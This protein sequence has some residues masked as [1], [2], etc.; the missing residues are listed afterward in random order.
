MDVHI[1]D[2]GDISVGL[3]DRHW[4]LS[5]VVLDDDADREEFRQETRAWAERWF[6]DPAV[7]RFSDEIEAEERAFAVG[8]E[9]D[10]VYT[11]RGPKRRPVDVEQ[12]GPTS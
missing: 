11:A 10:S 6:A 4:T 5:G 2:P 8:I 9:P 7:V 12:K 1:T 3:F